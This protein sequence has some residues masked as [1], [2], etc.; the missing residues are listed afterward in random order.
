MNEVKKL[1]VKHDS[2][3]RVI[4]WMSPRHRDML[5]ELAEFVSM[6]KKNEELIEKAYKK[7]Q[8]PEA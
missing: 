7:S 2:N 1:K 4:G 5:R 6:R 3:E 8:H